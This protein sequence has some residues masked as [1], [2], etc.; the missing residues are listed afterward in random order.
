[1]ML[2]QLERRFLAQQGLFDKIRGFFEAP[3]FGQSSEGKTIGRKIPEDVRLR[4]EA[5]VEKHGLDSYSHAVDATIRIGLFVL[6]TFP[7]VQ[8]HAAR[9]R[10]ETP[11]EISHVEQEQTS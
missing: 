5:V 2:E 1:M 4:L 9:L 11:K 6:E 8:N 3:S 10:R 7:A